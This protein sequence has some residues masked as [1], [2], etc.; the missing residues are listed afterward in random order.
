M[1]AT[2]HLRPM[3]EA[4]LPAALRLWAESDG[5]ELA[6]GD[7]REELAQ[8]L[9]RNP[10]MSFVATAGDRLVGAVLAGHDGRR[11]FL[12]HLAVAREHRGAHLG[13]NLVARSLAALKAARIT[14]VLVLVAC[15]NEPGRRFWAGQGWEDLTSAR[16]MGLNP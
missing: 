6:E 9:R 13:R 10:G 15:D 14:R 2:R 16:T 8:Y 12:Y 3:I 4:D 5:V 1:A 7:S 11:G